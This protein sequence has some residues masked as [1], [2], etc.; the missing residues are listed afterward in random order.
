V[1]WQEL[2]LN[3]KDKAKMFQ[4]DQLILDEKWQRTGVELAVL[5]M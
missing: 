5:L 4:I 2:I 3:Q 1:A